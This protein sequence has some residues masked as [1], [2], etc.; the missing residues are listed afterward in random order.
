MTGI[1]VFWQQ[2]VNLSCPPGAYTTPLRNFLNYHNTFLRLVSLQTMNVRTR[3][4]VEVSSRGL[5]EL[6]YIRHLVISSDKRNFNSLNSIASNGISIP[7][8]RRTSPHTRICMPAIR[9]QARRSWA[10]REQCTCHSTKV[11][12]WRQFLKRLLLVTVGYESRPTGV[13]RNNLSSTSYLGM[14][15]KENKKL[16]V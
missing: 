5:K 11:L 14:G 12:P 16:R 13:E 9:S 7:D 4:I 6:E 1:L 2:G 10:R 8:V 15:W 3:V